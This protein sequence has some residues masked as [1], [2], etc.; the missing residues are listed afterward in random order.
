VPTL[1]SHGR[2]STARRVGP[3]VREVAADE[4]E[5][6][7]ASPPFA[8]RTLSP[9]SHGEPAVSIE[10]AR[11]SH[12]LRASRLTVVSGGVGQ[13]S[14]VA[15]ECRDPAA[16]A[17]FYSR[18]TGWPVVHSNADWYS[19]GESENAGFHLSFQ[20]SPGHQPPTW[21][22]PASSMQLHLHFRVDDL[23]AAERA[24]LALGGTM[25]DDQPGDRS[26]VYAD[27]AGHPFCLVPT[28]DRIE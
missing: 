9:P 18:L 8:A 28:R 1:L 26:R 14:G 7:R 12:P 21:P 16:L 23:D 4:L 11:L 24:V 27:P 10:R 25:F 6:V 15:L 19:V 13:L 22:D 20:R 3:R 2:I 5:P 17:D